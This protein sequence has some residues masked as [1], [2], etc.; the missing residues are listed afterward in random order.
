MILGGE[1]VWNDLFVAALICS[2]NF[3]DG[4]E[5]VN[6]PGRWRLQSALWRI[7]LRLNRSLLLP[8]ELAKFQNYREA[9]AWSPATCDLKGG[10]QTRSLLAPRV[11]RLILMLCSKL[12]ITE[13]EALDFPMARA[14]AYQAA[15]LD[16][17][18]NIVLDGGS[19]DRNL[20]DH[21][22]RLEARAAKGEKVWDF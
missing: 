10:Y 2:L 20:L 21:L 9:G 16:A 22:A 8:T 12:N 5:I 3:K 19:G 4:L 15:E 6:R 11:Y 13:A 18:G 1:P 7:A 14:N 17:A